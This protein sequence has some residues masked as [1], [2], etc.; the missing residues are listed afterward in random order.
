MTGRLVSELTQRQYA[1]IGK[2]ACEWSH[3][4]TALQDFVR[5]AAD[6]SPVKSIKITAELGAV[7]L[8]NMI[9]ALAHDWNRP[10]DDQ[11]AL[12]TAIAHIAPLIHTMRGERNTVVHRDW[13]T[14]GQRRKLMGLRIDADGKLRAKQ[15]IHTTTEIE[16]L[17]QRIANL[18][19]KIIEIQIDYQDGRLVALP[20]KPHKQLPQGSRSVPK[21][22]GQ[23]RR[24]Q[25]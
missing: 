5:I 6:I 12:Y 23:G 14:S 4:E 8:L 19:R 22:K 13:F 10:D 18:H 25:P 17:A 7:T 24:S 2:V 9:L 20:P 21:G 3:L 11:P 1:A 16:A 15:I